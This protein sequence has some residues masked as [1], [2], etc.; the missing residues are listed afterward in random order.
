MKKN[1]FALLLFI[2]V[3]VVA[4]CTGDR[5]KPLAAFPDMEEYFP[6][7]E[8]EDLQT[9]LD[10]FEQKIGVAPGASDKEKADAYI[11]FNKRYVEFINNPDI[12]Y[13]ISPEDCL[14]LLGA[15]RVS[16]FRSNWNLAISRGRDMSDRPWI[17]IHIHSQSNFMSFLSALG[18]ELPAFQDLYGDFQ[19]SGDISPTIVKILYFDLTETELKDT[20]VRLTHMFFSVAHGL[21]FQTRP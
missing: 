21:M 18:K 20:R 3:A 16:T 7:E 19:K 5:S 14:E 11:R 8:I 6:K 9:M 2:A 12:P 13:P 17:S 10:L 4:G 1:I 15:I